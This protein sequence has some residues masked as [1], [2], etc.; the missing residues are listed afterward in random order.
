MYKCKQ[1]HEHSRACMDVHW[2]M[3]KCVQTN[4]KYVKAYQSLRRGS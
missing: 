3:R 1:A 4:E 2:Y